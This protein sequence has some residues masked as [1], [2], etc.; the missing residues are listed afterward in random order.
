MLEDLHHHRQRCQRA[1]KCGRSISVLYFSSFDRVLAAHHTY[2]LAQWEGR[3]QRW[4]YVQ[5]ATAISQWDIP[6]EPFIP[7]TSSTPHTVASPGPFQSPLPPTSNSEAEATKELMDLRSGKWRTSGS[8]PVC[9]TC[10]LQLFTTCP[11][12]LP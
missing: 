7:S 9:R 3:Q 11:D 8:Y 6:T 10:S 12:N 4:Y 2:R 5:P 1:G